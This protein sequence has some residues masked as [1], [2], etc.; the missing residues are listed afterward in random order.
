MTPTQPIDT[1]IKIAALWTAV[2]FVFAYVDLF[3]LYRPDVRADLDA[4][5][6]FVFDITEVFL[7]ATTLYVVV[8]SL[9]VYLSLVLP[10]RINRP[11]NIT[12]A[13]VYA[14]TILGSAVG[15][16]GYFIFGS[17]VEVALLATL[18]WHAWTWRAGPVPAAE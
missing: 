10:R 1:R 18:V 9:M 17:V 3:S 11:T 5:R 4:G 15:E 14:V 13:V 16:W 8:P 2:L 7:L 12:L 6:L